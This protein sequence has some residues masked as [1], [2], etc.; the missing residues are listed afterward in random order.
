M[1]EPREATP[2]EAA[3]IFAK[4]FEQTIGADIDRKAAQ[5]MR[6]EN[7][8]YD[9][10]EADVRQYPGT[11]TTCMNCSKV[12]D[13]PLAEWYCSKCSTHFTRCGMHPGYP[14]E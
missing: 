3:E 6:A 14:T 7:A 8:S 1:M 10:I 4:A 9:K 2:Q 5:L 13:T 11:K 12:K